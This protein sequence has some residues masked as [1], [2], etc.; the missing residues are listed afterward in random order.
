VPGEDVIESWR[1]FRHGWLRCGWN[2]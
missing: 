2:R 1:G